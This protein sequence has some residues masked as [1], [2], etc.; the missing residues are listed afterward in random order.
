[1]SAARI[2]LVIDRL[3]VEGVDLAHGEADTLVRLV[4]EELRR[5][6]D[7]GDRPQSRDVALIDAKPLSLGE[8]ADLRVLARA[9]AERV[10]AQAG[11]T[12]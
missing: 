11:L 6:T 2:D 4:E 9:L 12:R 10:A 7:A 1:M 8:P 5:L 3:V